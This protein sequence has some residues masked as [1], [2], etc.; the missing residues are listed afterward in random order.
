MHSSRVPALLGHSA[1]G[2]LCNTLAI[3]STPRRGLSAC[4]VPRRTHSSP[5]TQPDADL[6][7]ACV[8]TASTLPLRGGRVGRRGRQ[9]GLAATRGGGARGE[10]HVD[11]G[12]EPV[13]NPQGTAVRQQSACAAQRPAS[14][15]PTCC[16]HLRH[17]GAGCGCDASLQGARCFPAPP[18][19]T[20]CRGCI[21]LQTRRTAGD[22]VRVLWCCVL[23]L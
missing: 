20:E 2:I 21:A 11:Q 19:P 23:W 4:L 16:A 6:A 13:M 15:P 9:P 1:K 10:A 18:Q 17:W 22:Q 8:P 3:C 5:F 12:A 14:P 7:T